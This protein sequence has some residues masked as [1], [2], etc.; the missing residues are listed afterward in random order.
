M[1]IVSNA[2]GHRALTRSVPAAANQVFTYGDIVVLTAGVA[3]KGTIASTAIFGFAVAPLTTG[4]VVDV[5][6]DR[7][8]VTVATPFSEHKGEAKTGSS[9]ATT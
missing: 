1:E 4:A 6:T 7:L 3:S 2:F 9:T 8:Q 5:N